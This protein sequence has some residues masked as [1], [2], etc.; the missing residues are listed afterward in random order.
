MKTDLSEYDDYA[1]VEVK[2]NAFVHSNHP[3]ITVKDLPILP[4]DDTQKTLK[5][6]FKSKKEAVEFCKKI[7]TA[8][9][10][11]R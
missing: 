10:K 9:R 2:I 7:D 3:S 4:M 5:F 1:C 8:V 6:R 11:S